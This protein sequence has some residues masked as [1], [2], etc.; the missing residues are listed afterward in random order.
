[1]AHA[2]DRES[3]GIVLERSGSGLGRTRAV[4][5]RGCRD[6]GGRSGAGPRAAAARRDRRAVAASADRGRAPG[7]LRRFAPRVLRSGRNAARGVAARH[8]L[9]F[10]LAVRAR[11]SDAA[12]RRRRPGAHRGTGAA[13]PGPAVRSRPAQAARS[14]DGGVRE[15]A[16]GVLATARLRAQ[17]RTDAR[18]G[19]QAGAAQAVPGAFRAARAGAAA[20]PE[21]ERGALRRG[22]RLQVAGVDS[23]IAVAARVEGALL[24]PAARRA[25]RL[26]LD[27]LPADRTSR[28][29]GARTQRAGGVPGGHAGAR[30][31]RAAFHRDARR[32]RDGISVRGPAARRRR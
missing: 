12:A 25:R 19:V 29:R 13:A 31:R 7:D 23:P 10:P 28:A 15:S 20:A 27:R 2:R 14:V 22:D 30:R 3:G 5:L 6:A 4:H 24:G 9:A 32:R 8:R 16:R 11:A 17:D 26:R 21:R 18:R 1:M